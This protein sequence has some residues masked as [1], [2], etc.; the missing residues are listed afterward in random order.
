VL[1]RK[2]EGIVN[3]MLEYTDSMPAAL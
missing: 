1:E 3:R 2:E